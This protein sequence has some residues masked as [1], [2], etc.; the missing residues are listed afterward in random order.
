MVESKLKNALRHAKHYLILKLAPRKNRVYTQFYRFPNQYK[1]LLDVVLSDILRAG[2]EKPLEIAMFAC[3][4]G[5]EA[6]SL[7]H[8]IQSKYPQLRFRIRA[9]DIVSD[10]IEKANK[11]IYTKEQVY[12]GPF[13]TGDFVEKVFDLEND[14]YRVKAEIS[15]PI[16]FAVGDMLDKQFMESLGEVDIVFAQNVLFHLPKPQSREAFKNITRIL[17]RSGY[18]FINGMDVDMRVKLTKLLKLKPIDYLIEEIHNDAR[19]D[20]GAG[21]AGA[22]WGRQ[23]FSKSAREWMRK[24][25]TIFQ[26]T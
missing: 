18:M 25:C 24:Q 14:A 10:V 16:S 22:Y 2:D 3:C 1:T 11:P 9:Y 8:V 23:P 19:V 4:S 26:K 15:A 12:A 20:R 6:F 13:V 7:S 17:K 5:E 21:W